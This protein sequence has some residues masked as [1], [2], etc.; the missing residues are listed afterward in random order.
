MRL[1][2]QHNTVT[3]EIVKAREPVT[4]WSVLALGEDRGERTKPQDPASRQFIKKWGCCLF[5][6]LDIYASK[7]CLNAQ[8]SGFNF[9]LIGE[10]SFWK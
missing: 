5:L 1:R 4:V 8:Y 9:K 7:R 3:N 6:Q 2:R 10:I